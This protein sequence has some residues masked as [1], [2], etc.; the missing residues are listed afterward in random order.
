MDLITCKDE[1]AN[2][3]H[4]PATKA[5][6]RPSVYA[7]IIDEQDRILVLT[8][9][10]NG[11]YWFPGGGAE[12]GEAPEMTLTRELEEETNMHV[13]IVSLACESSFH[14]YCEP[15]DLLYD[16]HAQFFFC[17]PT[18]APED[19]NGEHPDPNL[20]SPQWI[21]V[22]ELTPDRIS[23][24]SPDGKLA[25]LICESLQRRRERQ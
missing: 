5:F 20:T 8:N 25:P 18:E 2:I 21:P 14:F 24:Y 23:D 4:I 7:L 10:I 17:S 3:V 9:R 13:D 6:H 22:S 12:D 15:E 19:L 16:M 11:K 1:K